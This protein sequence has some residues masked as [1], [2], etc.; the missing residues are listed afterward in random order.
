[1]NLKNTKTANYLYNLLKIKKIKERRKK[2]IDRDQEIKNY[3][4]HKKNNNNNKINKLNFKLESLFVSHANKAYWAGK[5]LSKIQHL[6]KNMKRNR[7]K[8]V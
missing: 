2:K 1:M 7:K 3:I 5:K 4:K 6:A 8:N